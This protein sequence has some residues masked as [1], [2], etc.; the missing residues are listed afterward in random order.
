MS[1]RAG[2]YLLFFLSG[3]CGLVYQV[4]W[5]RQFGNVFGNTVFSASL[6]TAVF[7]SGLG[8]G[9]FLAGRMADRRYRRD[10]DSL[11]RAYGYF[12]LGIG[13][14]GLFIA[15]LVPNLETLSAWISSYSE[16]PQG[17]F[18]LSSGTR[19]ARYLFVVLLLLPSTTLMGGTLTLL[20]R[21]LVRGD[22]RL[23]GFRIGALYGINTAGAALGAFSVDFLLVPT[24]GVL[25]S[26]AIA[27]VL[28]LSV[29]LVALRWARG[30]RGQESEPPPGL[31]ERPPA[32]PAQQDARTRRLVFLTA[33][34]ILLTG[35]VAMGLEILWFRYLISV[36]SARRSVFSLL[37][38]VVLVGIWWGSSA[39]GWVQRRWDRPAFMY[40]LTQSLF[41]IATLALFLGFRQGL[42]QHGGDWVRSSEWVSQSLFVAWASLKYILFLVGLPAFL[43]GFSFPLANAIVQRAEASVGTKA[44]VLY[45]SNTFGSVGGAL[46]AGFVL[47]PGLGTQGCVLV[48]AATGVGALVP[49]YFCMRSRPDGGRGFGFDDGIAAVSAIVALAFVIAW[50]NLPSN[51]IA[52]KTYYPQGVGEKVISFSEGVNETIMV[53]DLPSEAGRRL[54]TNGHRMSSTQSEAQRYMRGFA[55]IPLLQMESPETVVVICFGVGNSAHAATLHPSVTRVDVVDLS[56][57]ILEHAGYFEDSNDA[58]LEQPEVQVFV[59]DGRQHLRMQGDGVYDLVTLEPPPL[60]HAGVAALYSKEFYELAKVKLKPGGH[61][62]QWLPTHLVSGSVAESVVRAFIDVFPGA[63]LL[64]GV[65]QDFILLGRKGGPPIIDPVAV[66]ARLAA[67][68]ELAEDMRRIRLGTALEVVGTF[69]GSARAIDVATRGQRPVTDDFPIIEYDTRSVAAELLPEGFFSVREVASWCPACF[70]AE[71]RPVPE[72]EGLPLYLEFL[73]TEYLSLSF[74]SF[75]RLEDV[76]QRRPYHGDPQDLVR[77]WE[78]SPFLQT[79]FERPSIPG[80][81][82]RSP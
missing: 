62:T 57:H 56:Q 13:G 79:Q 42:F 34:A 47:L 58:V 30:S 10:P 64:S 21:H 49:L 23:A 44:G 68:P 11:L 81:D 36:L 66:A 8:I 1:K 78:R 37:L 14:F 20:I 27:A 55:H 59:N 19:L 72:V 45:L 7:M 53:T 65:G 82:T 73:E 2:V 33:L 16:G 29:G 26:Q 67:S 63:V 41:I 39:G 77:L 52:K 38:T 28:N 18:V 31:V 61:M 75:G 76:Q 25:A 15:F 6:V 70:D 3:I 80:D 17:W 69:A 51:D 60:G 24:M 9:S 71:G 50:A 48:L 74:R 4:L 40:L 12:E 5:V 22:L 35:F 32:A 43:M 46:M 54:Y